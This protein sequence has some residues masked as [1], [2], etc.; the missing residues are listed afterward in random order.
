SRQASTRGLA[1]ATETPTRILM[2]PTVGLSDS[3]FGRMAR[4]VEVLA[5]G[6]FQPNPSPAEVST[7]RLPSR[8]YWARGWVVK[9]TDD[10]I[11]LSPFRGATSGPFTLERV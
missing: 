3:T 10:S 2:E 1:S 11:N 5:R 9:S 8:L 4:G 7:D 6:R